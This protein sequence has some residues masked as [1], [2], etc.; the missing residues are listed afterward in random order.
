MNNPRRGSFL[1]STPTMEKT[2]RDSQVTENLRT[3]S[4]RTPME[5]PE[6]DDDGGEIL[7]DDNS[8]TLK[9]VT[10]KRTHSGEEGDQLVEVT[11]RK[12]YNALVS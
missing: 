1:E 3:R 12:T 2:A 10:R 9:E 7:D 8:N 6:K 5:Q 4:T 11:K